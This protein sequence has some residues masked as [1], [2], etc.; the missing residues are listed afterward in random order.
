M[1]QGIG[2]RFAPT[3]VRVLG[4]ERSGTGF[5]VTGIAAGAAPDGIEAFLA[6]H[7]FDTTDAVITI[8]L[9]PGDFLSV[10]LAREPG[11]TDDDM[12]EQLYWEIERKIIAGAED[13][14]IK[15]TLGATVGFAFA[16]RRDLI[17]SLKSL[18]T[19]VIDTDPVALFN[20]CETAGEIGPGTQLL[21][22]VDPDGVAGVLL[23]DGVVVTMDAAPLQEQTVDQVF[24]A[25][26]GDESPGA[27]ADVPSGAEFRFAD[28]AEEAVGRMSVRARD[29]V[30]GIVLAGACTLLPGFVAAV[31]E[32][33]GFP[34]TVSNPF[35]GLDVAARN[36]VFAERG[37]MFTTAFGMA[38]RGLEEE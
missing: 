8:G 26:L 36:P 24:T 37:P 18:G 19:V 38:V 13:Y 33:V 4:L 20:G 12:L 22:S 3:G 30:D 6:A 5:E 17:G 15:P 11:F 27:F 10:F 29:G 31:S 34:V 35:A 28:H 32:R 23:A 14:I 9:C 7:G 21:L 25:A 1:S 2:I 16:G